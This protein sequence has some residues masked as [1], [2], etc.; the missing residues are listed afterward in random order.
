MA[1]A[2]TVTIERGPVTGNTA[3]NEGGGLWNSEPGTLTVTRAQIRNDPAPVGPNVFQD[4]NGTGFTID[5]QTV[6]PGGA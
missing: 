1:G 4:G 2:G 5:G 6:P 3:S